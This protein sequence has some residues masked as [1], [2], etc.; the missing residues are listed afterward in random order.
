MKFV[1]STLLLLT[2][3]IFWLAPKKSTPFS[4]EAIQADV[5][6]RPEWESRG[7]SPE[8]DRVV[9]EAL[10]QP[11]RYLGCGGQCYAFASSDDQYVVKFFKQKPFTVAP[12]IA[13]FPI[14]ILMDWLKVKKSEKKEKIRSNVFNAFKVSLAHLSQ[15]TGMLYVH[16]NRTSDLNKTLSVTDADGE[17]HLLPLDDLEFALQKK[18]EL[19]F[20]RIDSLMQGSDVEG[21]KRAVYKLLKLNLELY[22]KGY[23]N[24]DPNFHSNYGFI[25]EEAILIDVGRLVYTEEIKAA[26]NISKEFKK[27]ALRFRKYLADNYPQLLGHFEMRIEEITS[28]V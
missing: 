28:K 7:M 11:Y 21:A 24:R 10:S 5:H 9:R 3:F 19:A 4:R 1:L 23:R 18:A 15:E 27:V 17:P 6:F 22:Q 13:K 25:G 26:E 8:E 16:L 12:W 2:A 14:P 20:Q